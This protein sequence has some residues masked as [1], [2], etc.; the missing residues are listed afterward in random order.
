M[1][2]LD[3]Q[4]I[5]ANPVRAGPMARRA[6]REYPDL[7]VH[8]GRPARKEPRGILVRRASQDPRALPGRTGPTELRVNKASRDPWDHQVL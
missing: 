6:H 4:E 5:P 2:R 3:L 8:Q 7:P 1:V